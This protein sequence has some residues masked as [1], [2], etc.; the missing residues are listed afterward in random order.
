VSADGG[1]PDSV[2]SLNAAAEELRYSTLSLLPS[3]SVL[4]DVVFGSTKRPHVEV[5]A[6][7]GANRRVVLEDARA[8]QY[9]APGYLLFQR[10]D[11]VMLA[12][13][14]AAR[15]GVTGA[16]VPLTDAIR[17]DGTPASP[18]NTAQIAVSASGTVAYVG[19]V[20]QIGA[21][22]TLVAADGTAT[23]VGRRGDFSYVRRSPNGQQL[24]VSVPQPDGSG[25]IEIVDLVRGTT[26]RLA[27]EGNEQNAAWHPNGRQLALVGRREKESGIFIRDLDGGQRL[28]VPSP[29]S[30]VLVNMDW[31]PDGTELAY[32]RQNASLHDIFIVKVSD[33]TK[34]V[35]SLQGT[36]SE[37]SPRFSP[38]GRWLAFVS[39]ESGR[40]EVYV[41]RLPEGP[42]VRVSREG[43]T[44][45]AWGPDGRTLFYQTRGDT[46]AAMMRAPLTF[47]RDAIN[48]GE[49]T[50]LF[51][52]R[53]PGP[54][55]AV[56]EYARS[57]N[58]GSRFDVL[59]DGRFIMLRGADPRGTREIV[60]IQNFAEEAKRLLSVK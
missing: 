23:P 11:L 21:A 31:S 9:V 53:G 51:D 36:A 12:P 5:V 37:F 55:G 10:D 20:D 3:G 24:A 35:A 33:P 49:P 22:L 41:Q 45:F 32:T 57:T 42:R 15:A 28:L 59:P 30:G 7:D 43:S 44:G 6:A 56:E 34:P 8:P 4:F 19:A 54:T 2:T 27:H 13:F 16:A 39:D 48:V 1:T 17:R 58:T 52:L 18:G 14:D 47:T 25:G 50:K 40:G 26:T 46:A 29:E 60:L 38:D